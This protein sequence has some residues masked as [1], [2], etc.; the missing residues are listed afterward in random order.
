MSAFMAWS[1]GNHLRF[2]TRANRWFHNPWLR[3]LQPSTCEIVDRQTVPLSQK[4]SL[5]PTRSLLRL[6]ELAAA[7]CL[8]VLFQAEAGP[9]AR[10][11]PFSLPFRPVPRIGTLALTCTSQELLPIPSDELP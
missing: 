4:L 11:S 1:K 2:S 10:F 8:Q 7:C 3:G 9:A 5:D 6:S